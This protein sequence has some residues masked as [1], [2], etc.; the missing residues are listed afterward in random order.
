MKQTTDEKWVHVSCAL[1]I[2]GVSFAS[3]KEK[4]PVR[5]VSKV[6]SNSSHYVL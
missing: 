3:Y 2:P 6:L 1:G 4:E 5:N